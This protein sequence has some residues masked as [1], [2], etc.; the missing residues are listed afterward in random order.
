MFPDLPQGVCGSG[1]RFET[2]R[3]AVACEV[4]DMEAYALA[5]VCHLEG[6]EFGAVKFVTDGADG[7]AGVD[8]QAN[9]PRAARAFVEHYQRLLRA[10]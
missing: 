3:P 2:G 7:D 8:W 6:A 10:S 4:I 9:L 1:D 5:K